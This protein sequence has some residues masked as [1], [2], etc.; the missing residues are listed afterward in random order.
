MKRLEDGQALFAL[1]DLPIGDPCGDIVRL[2]ESPTSQPT[3]WDRAIC[4]G[5]WMWIVSD[6]IEAQGGI[7]FDPLL[8]NTV[9]ATMNNHPIH[10]AQQVF[11]L[12]LATDPFL[13]LRWWQ[14]DQ[15]DD[16]GHEKWI[17]SLK[18][19]LQPANFK[20]P[21]CAAL[22]ESVRASFAASMLVLVD[23]LVKFIAECSK[24]GDVGGAKPRKVFTTMTLTGYYLGGY[25][26]ALNQLLQEAN[27]RE[28][29]AKALAT[30]IISFVL[31]AV[32]IPFA[33][34]L[35]GVVENIITSGAEALVDYVSPLIEGE[36][37]SDK[38][39]RFEDVESKINV[40]NLQE[41]FKLLIQVDKP[42]AREIY[43]KV[44]LNP[45]TAVL[46]FPS[47]FGL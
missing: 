27:A 6:F 2:I 43:D 33:D 5:M 18:R 37:D 24:S 29:E 19:V 16:T 36:V 1:A 44:V 42:C 31:K 13:V 39:R 28:A 3:P 21:S 11:A 45:T 41:V 10:R 22:T 26:I 32:P 8:L 23:P 17:P 38:S 14:M 9:V 30:S 4:A 46:H 40:H 25:Q 12:L 35:G 47:Q 15:N 7:T 34:C 20:C